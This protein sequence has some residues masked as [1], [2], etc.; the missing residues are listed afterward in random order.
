[1]RKRAVL[2]ELGSLGV[3]QKRAATLL[4]LA[5]ANV[6]FYCSRLGVK[7]PRATG[8]FAVMTERSR[9]RAEVMVALYRAGYTLKQIGDQYGLTRER[10]RQLMTKHFDVSH[11]DGGHHVRSVANHEKQA[12][13]KNDRYLTKHGCTWDQYAGVRAIG[14]A[15]TAAG[16]HYSRTPT[17]AFNSQRFNAAKRGIGWDLMFWEWWTIWQQSG[18]WQERGRGQGYVM[19]R[20][21]DVGHYAIGNVFV[22]KATE[23]SSDAQAHGRLDPSLPIGVRQT[24]SGRYLAKRNVDGQQFHLGTHDTPEL[25]HAAYL[26][27]GER[28]AA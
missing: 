25:A 12:A 18:H 5:P 15:M 14:R 22:A 10:V 26:M 4:K 19:C 23:N 9:K 7:L 17:G 6:S 11:R 13:L 8:G 21:G 20:R 1:M 28:R 24:K 16:I 2:M 27:A 3:S